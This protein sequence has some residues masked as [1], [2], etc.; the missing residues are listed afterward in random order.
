MDHESDQLPDDKTPI[1]NDDND[2]DDWTTQSSDDRD[3]DDDDWTTQSSDDDL[4]SVSNAWLTTPGLPWATPW[5]TISRKRQRKTCNL[6][7]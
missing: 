2:E 1:D 5:T 6:S 7:K 4:D 3:D